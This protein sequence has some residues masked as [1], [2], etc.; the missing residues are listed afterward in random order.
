M[1]EGES[2]CVRVQREKNGLKIRT[3]TC[4]KHSSTPNCD[5]QCQD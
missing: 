2:E 3:S 5:C 4:N 1:V